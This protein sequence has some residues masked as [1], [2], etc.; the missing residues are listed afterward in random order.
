VLQVRY[1]GQQIRCRTGFQAVTDRQVGE[2]GRGR[3]E[4][5]RQGSGGCHGQAGQPRGVTE[6]IGWQVF[7]S[8]P[9]DPQGLQPGRVGQQVV[10]IGVSPS[11][12]LQHGKVGQAQQAVPRKIPAMDIQGQGPNAGQ[13]AP[14]HLRTG[15]RGILQGMHGRQNALPDVPRSHT[16]GSMPARG[17]ARTVSYPRYPVPSTPASST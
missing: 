10:G 2:P 13:M 12:H 3:Q 17:Q 14:V 6:Q 16:W 11:R 1:G 7:Q 15:H 9:L 4:R 5:L 8:V